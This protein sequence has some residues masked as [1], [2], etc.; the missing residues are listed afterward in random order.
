MVA[1]PPD[2][3][4]MDFMQ[5]ACRGYNSYLFALMEATPALVRRAI[6]KAVKT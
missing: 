4:I 5:D 6:K 1:T 2:L 3:T